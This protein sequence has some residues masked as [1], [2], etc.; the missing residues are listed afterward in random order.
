MKT[1]QSFFEN[2]E[3][4]ESIKL[5]VDNQWMC[6]LIKSISPKT[7]L[8]SKPPETTKYTFSGN[9]KSLGDFTIEINPQVHSP[10]M[11]ILFGNSL[12]PLLIS[13]DNMTKKCAIKTVTQTKN[14]FNFEALLSKTKDYLKGKKIQYGKNKSEVIS[15][16]KENNFVFSS[17]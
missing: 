16:V 3:D 9:S 1:Y 12:Y 2:K 11:T 10:F 8:L 7:E 6:E 14:Q 5:F 15:L 17:F 4:W 13:Y